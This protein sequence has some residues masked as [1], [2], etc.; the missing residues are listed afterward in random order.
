M[1]SRIDFVN[2]CTLEDN[3]IRL[4]TAGEIIIIDSFPYKIIYPE[5]TK[6]SI[7]LDAYY[8]MKDECLQLKYGQGLFS[9]LDEDAINDQE[10]LTLEVLH[11]LSFCPS[12]KSWERKRLI[13]NDF[14]IFSKNIDYSSSRLNRADYHK[15]DIQWVFDPNICEGRHLL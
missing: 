11:K 4:T 7:P 14:K 6:S 8:S 15:Y 1:I 12:I 2:I 3:K 5:L 10:S 13:E 9:D